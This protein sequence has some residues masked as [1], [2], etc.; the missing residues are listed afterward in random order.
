LFLIK[1]TAVL[2][3]LV[4]IRPTCIFVDTA[5]LCFVLLNLVVAVFQL[6]LTHGLL[7]FY[8]RSY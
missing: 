8:R 5:Y 7:T 1:L 3:R 2:K 6:V 4:S